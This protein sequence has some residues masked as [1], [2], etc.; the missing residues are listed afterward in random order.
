[1][2]ETMPGKRYGGIFAWPDGPVWRYLP[3]APVPQRS[4]DGRAQ[5][6]AVEA[7][8]MLMIT[9]GTSLSASDA[10]LDEARAAIAAETKGKAETVDLR[11]A[12]ALPK[13]ATLTLTLT[14]KPAVQLARANPSPVPPYPAAFSA[15]L[16]GEQAKQANA[17]LKSGS[18]RL[19]VTYEMDV[20]M[21]RS[22][23]AR[24]AG[25]PG[26][27][28]DLEAALADGDLTL[29]LEADE[30]ASEALKEDARRGVLEEAERLFSNFAP[31]AESSSFEDYATDDPADFGSDA[32]PETISATAIDAHATR[33]EPAPQTLR[34]VANVADWL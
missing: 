14:G 10:Q 17:A 26:K 33:T 4:A 1:M 16:Q 23:T 2:T 29:S 22:A 25:K 24:L 28:R 3:D 32:R 11:P 27:A 31:A 9:L 6:T 7:G 34:L 8:E 20:A 19:D 21:S 5:L 15:M 18:G 12:E 30:G 13:A